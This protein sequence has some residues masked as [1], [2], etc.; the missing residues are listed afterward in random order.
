MQVFSNL[1]HVFSELHYNLVLKEGRFEPSIHLDRVQ[2]LNP[3]TTAGL[4]IRVWLK[5]YESVAKLLRKLTFPVL[6]ISHPIHGDAFHYV[7]PADE[8]SI[9]KIV[10]W[11]KPHT[12]KNWVV[13]APGEELLE[14]DRRLILDMRALSKEVK[15]L[16]SSHQQKTKS[17]KLLLETKTAWRHRDAPEVISKNLVEEFLE[18]NE[19]PDLFICANEYAATGTFLALR[20]IGIPVPDKTSILA[21]TDGGRYFEKMTGVRLSGIDKQ[22]AF[23]G[24]VAAQNLLLAIRDPRAKALRTEVPGVY[25]PGETLHSQFHFEEDVPHDSLT[26]AKNTRKA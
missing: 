6:L 21:I 1:E 15:V 14:T 10:T 7:Y 4:I 24:S 22:T 16:S 19:V 8:R 23:L 17:N 11:L 25:S 13:V 18:K 2:N 3:D 20:K 5:D 12:K 9:G 26:K